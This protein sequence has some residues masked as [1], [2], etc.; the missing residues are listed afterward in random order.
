[1]AVLIVMSGERK[2]DRLEILRKRVGIGRADD[3]ELALDDA[4]V[5]GHHCEV[6]RDGDVY[7]LRDLGS[8]NGTTIN[9]APV[10]EETLKPKDLFAAGGVEIMID[11]DDIAFDA[12]EESPSV[13]DDTTMTV[14]RESHGTASTA[15]GTKKDA[16]GIWFVLIGLLI[17]L[18][19]GAMAWFLYSLFS[20]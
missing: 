12:P 15:F 19:L 7:T 13:E 16:R 20:S 5:S 17:V 2:G 10:R 11:G 9:G 14:S 4:S 3:N 18:A 6:V 1:M 8:T